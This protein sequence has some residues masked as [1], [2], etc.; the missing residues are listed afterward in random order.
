MKLTP[1]YIFGPKF[2][3]HVAMAYIFQG[4]VCFFVWW[5]YR[6]VYDLRR[7]YFNSADYQASLHSRTLLLTH[8]P[9]SS[10]TDAGI[11]DLLRT[12]EW[13]PDVPRS[14]IGRNVKDLPELIRAHDRAVR[15]LEV[16]KSP[17][18]S[19][20]RLRHVFTY[21]NILCKLCYIRCWHLKSQFRRTLYFLRAF[22][23]F[24]PRP[25]GIS[26]QIPSRPGPVACEKADLQARQGGPACQWKAEDGCNRLLDRPHLDSGD[27]DQ[28]R[29][30]KH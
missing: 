9:K 19:E 16:S 11:V 2:W 13:S 21:R 3:A 10:R 30:R 29:P 23:D 12:D 8:I 6:K 27:R 4:T 26:G 18:R 28:E 15:E 14:A 20:V 22:T 1:Q 17:V 7:A 5:N 24:V 25:S